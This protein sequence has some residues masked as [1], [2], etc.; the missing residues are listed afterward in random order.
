MYFDETWYGWSTQGPLQVLLFSA[1]FAQGADP[2][3]AKKDHGGPLLK[4]IFFTQEGFN[5]KPKVSQW[6]RSMWEEVLLFFVPF[7][8]EK[9]RD[10]TQSYGKDPY[11]HRKIQK[12]TW[13]HKHASKTSITQR[14]RTDLGRSAGATTATQLVWLNRF[15]STKPSH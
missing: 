6:S 5:N 9:G 3:Q 12:A 10:L 7:Q 15:T 11:T 2:G 8:R 14:L 13:Q 4:K 1:R